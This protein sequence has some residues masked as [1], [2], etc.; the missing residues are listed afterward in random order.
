LG[1]QRR[2][3][4]RITGIDNVKGNLDRLNRQGREAVSKALNDVG[5][6]VYSESQRRTPVDTGNLKASGRIA[7]SNADGLAAVITYGGTAADYA[8][9]VHETHK[10]QSKFLESALRDNERR[11]REEVADAIKNATK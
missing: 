7:P 8:L 11:L 3:A 9:V 5:N 2:L 1:T 6:E 4:V 10:T